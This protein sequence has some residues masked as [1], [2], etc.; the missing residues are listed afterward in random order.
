MSAT[1]ARKY[2]P[3]V[4]VFAALSLAGCKTHSAVGMQMV[5]PPGAQILDVQEDA[6]FL[7]A[8]PVSQPMPVFPAGVSGDSDVGVCVEMVVDESGAIR[9]A[10]PVYELPEC[11]LDSAKI[12]GRYV[13]SAVA[14]VK[15]WQFLAAATCSF[16]PGATK[17][18]DCSGS[19]VVVSPIA[20]KLSYAFSF[21]RGGRVTAKAKRV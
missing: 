16:P 6:F 17:T 11:P 12:D 19:D 4:A 10:R 9:T 2:L 18:E 8:S 15:Q 3:V 14:A 1:L 20:I 7:M 5:L 13:A 21:Q